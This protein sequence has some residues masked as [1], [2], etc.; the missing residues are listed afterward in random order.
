M[1]NGVH[2]SSQLVAKAAEWEN[3]SQFSFVN[4]QYSDTGLFGISAVGHEHVV[5]EMMVHVV[6]HLCHSVRGF[7]ICSFM[8]LLAS[9]MSAMKTPWRLLRPS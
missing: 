3:A 8:S 7:R 1:G 5:E 9:H 2:S 6:Y 4:T